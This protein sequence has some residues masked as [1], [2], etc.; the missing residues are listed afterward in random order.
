STS[1]TTEQYP[2][3]PSYR[4]HEMPRPATMPV[5][6]LPGRGDGRV[7]QLAVF[8]ADFTTS[9]SRG[10]AR[11][12]SRY[13]TGSAFTDAAISSMND[14]CANVFCN[15]AGARN[16]PVKNGDL[17]SCVSTRW[18]WIFPVPPHCAPTQPV[19]YDGTALLLFP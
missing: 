8:A 13:S 9:I 7:S 1:A 18:L 10:S 19:T 12:R 17:T 14:S 2:L 15:R 16:G 4:T 11:C 6:R 5:R 3:S